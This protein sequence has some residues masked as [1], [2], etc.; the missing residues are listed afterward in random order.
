M[1]LL[2]TKKYSNTG[3]SNHEYACRFGWTLEIQL[4][5]EEYEHACRCFKRF[6]EMERIARRKVQRSIRFRKSILGQL[7]VRLAQVLNS[8]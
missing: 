2:S 4:S 3:M 5:P 7:L 8:G 6:G 1:E